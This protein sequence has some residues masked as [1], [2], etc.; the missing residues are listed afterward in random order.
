MGRLQRERVEGVELI[1]LRLGEYPKNRLRK[2][3]EKFVYTGVMPSWAALADTAPAIPKPKPLNGDTKP[4]DTQ[5]AV[6]KKAAQA[7]NGGS[8]LA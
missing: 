7:A 4:K 2:P 5:A 8:E 3:G 6:Q 1:A